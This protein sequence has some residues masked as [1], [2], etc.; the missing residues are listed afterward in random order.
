MT[1]IMSDDAQASKRRHATWNS[2][3]PAIR[4]KLWQHPVGRV[5]GDMAPSLHLDSEI[6]D[7]LAPARPLRG[8][9]GVELR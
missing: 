6:P 1:V 2:V 4:P 9:K 5:N 8:Q 3:S 7:D